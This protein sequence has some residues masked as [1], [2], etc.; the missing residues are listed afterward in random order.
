MTLHLSLSDKVRDA[1]E[2]VGVVRVGRRLG[3][4]LAK[5]LGVLLVGEG[6]NAFGE[7][8]E[9][10]VFRGDGVRFVGAASTHV[11]SAPQRH[12]A[13]GMRLVG[14][15]QLYRLVARV[16]LLVHGAEQRP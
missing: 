8:R 11:V 10:S 15:G 2:Q 7:R 16:R 14:G 4:G 3:E 1:M 6:R 12:E 13:G 5:G 9:L